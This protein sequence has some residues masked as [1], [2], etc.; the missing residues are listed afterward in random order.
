M[1]LEIQKAL[2][3]ST[4]CT[5]LLQIGVGIGANIISTLLSSTGIVLLS[6]N[7]VNVFL[8]EC[9]ELPECSLIKSFISVSTILLVGVFTCGACFQL[10]QSSV[11]KAYNEVSQC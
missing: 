11:T 10:H 7:L 1:C 4:K 9:L 3:T 5:V 2:S 6:K 8:F